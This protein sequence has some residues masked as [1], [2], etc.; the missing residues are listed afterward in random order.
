MCGRFLV[1]ELSVVICGVNFLFIVIFVKLCVVFLV[2]F[3]FELYSISSGVLWV[4]FVFLC[5]F[6]VDCLVLGE[7]ILLS[8]IFFDFVFIIKFLGFNVKVFL[9]FSL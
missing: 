2:V 9:I 1:C 5:I 4:F 3:I 8:G 7:G 6:L